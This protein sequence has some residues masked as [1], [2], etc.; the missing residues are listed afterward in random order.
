[1][2]IA[3]VSGGMSENEKTA[4]FN[5]NAWSVSTDGD[6]ADKPFGYLKFA[7]GQLRLYTFPPD[8][9]VFCSLMKR[10]NDFT[11]YTLPK[12]AKPTANYN[13]YK[14]KNDFDAYLDSL[15]GHNYFY[16]FIQVC[17]NYLDQRNCKF[18][19]CQSAL[20]IRLQTPRVDEK[21]GIRR[22]QEEIF[23]RDERMF[24]ESRKSHYDLV[25]KDEA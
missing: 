22:R 20:N 18:Y 6:L 19:R 4:L 5:Q 23:N 8:Y 15:K 21:M 24:A 3:K 1:M 9:Q 14:W 2:F 11:Q 16:G 25:D 7:N 17:L 12:Q 13:K 10:L